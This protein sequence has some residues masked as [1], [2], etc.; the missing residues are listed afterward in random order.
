MRIYQLLFFT[1][2]SFIGH[3][4]ETNYTI[5]Y[6]VNYN[7]D[8]KG[9]GLDKL[10]IDATN[11]KSIYIVGNKNFQPIAEEDKA[12]NVIYITNKEKPKEEIV[13]SDYT[14]NLLYSRVVPTKALYFIKEP[15]PEMN[16]KLHDETKTTKENVLLHKATLSFRGRNYTVWYSMDYPIHIGPWKF[17]N[18]PGL[19]FEITEEDNRYHWQLT[20]IET[21]KFKVLP[22]KYD[23]S[24]AT[25][26]LQT[27]LT[28]YQ[29][30]VENYDMGLSRLFG[31]IPGVEVLE[32]ITD[33]D[34]FKKSRNMDLER[35]YEW[36]D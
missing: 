31:S 6:Q 10:Y 28:S 8:V 12:P 20:K 15:I 9:Q 3:A 33:K 17:N 29:A 34:D 36:E 5:S 11:N 18:L 35:K 2:L 19:A 13:Y 24:R 25:M 7:M 14:T 22:M 26:T 21:N 23:I 1:I 4:Q 16:W 27:Y 30:E 32:T